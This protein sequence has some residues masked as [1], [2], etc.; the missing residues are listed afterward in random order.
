[1]VEQDK[2]I[3]CFLS[4]GQTLADLFSALFLA[5]SSQYRDNWEQH[6]CYVVIVTPDKVSAENLC[7]L[8]TSPRFEV[9]YADMDSWAFDAEYPKTAH[10]LW[11]R[12]PWQ[13]R[14]GVAYEGLP[15][16]AQPKPVGNRLTELFSECSPEHPAKVCICAPLVAHRLI[17]NPLS[18]NV[19]WY[20]T[21]TTRHLLLNPAIMEEFS[22]RL[23]PA[24]LP[25]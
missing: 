1:M 4:F 19:S 9:L 5:D 6:S 12:E 15:L 14:Q 2:L 20:V 22:S 25:K 21:A 13:P 8:F 3:V 16:L 10:H 11:P 17:S 24:K 23:L 18:A 7:K